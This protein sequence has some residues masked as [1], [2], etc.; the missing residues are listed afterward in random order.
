MGVQAELLERGRDGEARV[1]EMSDHLPHEVIGWVE[2]AVRGAGRGLREKGEEAGTIALGFDEAKKDADLGD[3][4]PAFGIGDPTKEVRR[5]DLLQFG[6]F[7]KA[8]CER[9]IDAPG[10]DGG[11]Q[12]RLNCPE[13]VSEA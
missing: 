3:I 2:I 10:E 1:A 4:T 6:G 11:D 7:R 9:V 8:A 12:N 5:H 13:L